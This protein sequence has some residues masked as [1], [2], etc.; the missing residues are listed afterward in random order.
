MVTPRS[1]AELPVNGSPARHTAPSRASSYRVLVYSH[2]SFGLG[3]LRRCRAIAHAL[4]GQHKKLNV[5]I[6]SG[7]PIIGRFSFRARVDFVRV[8][9]IIKL[10]NGEYTSLSLDVNLEHTL[11]LRASIIEHTAQ[12]FDPHLFLVDK[13]PLGLLGEVLKTLRMLKRRGGCRLV[14]GL[15]DIMDDPG[16]LAVEW[17]RKRVLP[18]LERLYDQI[19]VYGL[20]Q[21]YD[22]VRAYEFPPTVAAK[23]VFTGYLKREPQADVHLPPGLGALAKQPFLLVTP[24]GG[25]DGAELVDATLAAYE[26]FNGRL[27]WPALIVYGPFLPAGQRASF[28]RRAARLPRIATLTFHEHLENLMERAAAVVCLGGYNTF[29]EVISLNKRSLIVPRVTPRAEQLLR[30]EAARELGLVRVLHPAELT[31]ETLA[32]A[33]VQLPDRPLPASHRIP[34]LLN[35]LKYINATVARWRMAELEVSRAA[36]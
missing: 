24:G 11:A 4:V 22:P 18:A 2:D 3:H 17:R 21:I 36:V 12:V 10:R 30:A 1:S 27:P 13:E 29:C 28:E 8:P 23:T 9:G 7:S 5:L 15:R 32:E 20:P 6:L 34:G 35:G 26:R 31:P 25:G 19:W 16:S 14:L 33:L